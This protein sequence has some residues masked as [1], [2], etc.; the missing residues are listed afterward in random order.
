M[1]MDPVLF[2]AAATIVA[3]QIQARA[4]KA[5]T[6]SPM[7]APPDLADQLAAAYWKVAA[8]AELIAKG[9]PTQKG[10]VQQGFAEV[11]DPTA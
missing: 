4:V 3:G 8:A 1:A 7:F 5:T 11:S 10:E 9:N 2:Q 6:T